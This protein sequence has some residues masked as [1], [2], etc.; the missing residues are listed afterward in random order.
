[1]KTQSQNHKHTAIVTK[2]PTAI[3]KLE[4]HAAAEGLAKSLTTFA[5]SLVKAGPDELAFG[6]A[7]V[8]NFTE[9]LKDLG[10]HI[11]QKLE[12]LI[13]EKG[14]KVT[15]KGT[16]EWATPTGQTIRAQPNR[17]GYDPK[18]LEALLR[19]AKVEPSSIMDAKITYTVNDQKLADFM[20]K[21][22]WTDEDV[23]D[24]L[25]ETTYSIRLGGKSDGA[26]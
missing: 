3:G 2:K 17:T 24:A 26:E 1:M 25:Y 22:N 16:Y 19:A 12:P 11:D 14:A 18:K 8:K 10:H 15:D 6:K 9:G 4:P 13:L 21:N 5:S 20:L 7:Q 23:K